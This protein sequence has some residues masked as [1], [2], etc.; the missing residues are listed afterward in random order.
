MPSLCG[1][2]WS[3]VDVVVGG[4]GMS[5]TEGADSGG[6]RSG[7]LWSVDSGWNCW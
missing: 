6:V 5:A 3:S 2:N 7:D 4:C 1:V